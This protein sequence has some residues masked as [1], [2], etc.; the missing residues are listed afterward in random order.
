MTIKGRALLQITIEAEVEFDSTPE[1]VMTVSSV[2]ANADIGGN[3]YTSIVDLPDHFSERI[4][5]ACA[6]ASMRYI[7][8]HTTEKLNSMGPRVLES[9]IMTAV[10]PTDPEK[11]N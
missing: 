8:H 1:G 3:I 11:L 5:C 7:S 6:D 9:H 4:K 10:K 2:Q